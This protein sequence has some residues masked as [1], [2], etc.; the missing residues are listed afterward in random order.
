MTD[1]EIMKMALDTLIDAYGLEANMKQLGACIDALRDRLEN[2]VALTATMHPVSLGIPS[3]CKVSKESLEEV[4]LE[5]WVGL[6]NE[7]MQGYG[8][9]LLSPH[10][11]I[12]DVFNSIEA[13]LKEKNG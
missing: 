12:R 4:V 5:K 6:T 9:D 1:R 10:K 13:K 3:E 7:E 2:G 8:N 11:S